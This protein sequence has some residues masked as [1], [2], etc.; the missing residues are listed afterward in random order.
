MNRRRFIRTSAVSSL[1]LLLSRGVSRGF[2]ESVLASTSKRVLVLGGTDFVGPAVVE[3]L[4]ING[5]AVTLFNRGM[6]NPEFNRGMTNPELFSV[7]ERLKGFRS[8]DPKDQDLSALE[9]RH[10]DVAIDIWPNEPEIVA[11]AAEVLK[12][13]T[14]HY[15][16]VSSV[17]AY[18]RKL[19]AKPDVITEDAPMQ[20]WNEQASQYNRNKAE[21]ERR[22]HRIIGEKLTIV[23]PTRIKGHREHDSGPSNL[24]TWLLRMQTGG[25]HIGPGDGHDPFQLVDVKDVARFLAL[26][27]AK[28]LY[29]TFNLTGKLLTFRDYL[30]ECKAA[31]HS[32][33]TLTWI[34]QQFLHEYGLDPD[35][36]L[37]TRAGYFPSWSPEVQDQGVC[38]V[39][40]EKAFRAGWELRPF[41]E[42]AYDCLLDFRSGQ[43]QPST[44]LSPAKEKE[45]LEAWKHRPS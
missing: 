33:T 16:F 18:D 26:A 44:L 35:S 22:L 8:P 30:E 17:G 38:R 39:S 15:L 10:F 1:G 31:T 20:P 43:L 25:E 24:L 4:L 2:I 45:V 34:P 21:S 32:D 19:F 13:R 5:H 9:H 3:A 14:N 36:A 28:A 41:E 23:R 6:T 12:N 11:S 7:V 37:T 40:S 27:I 42:T 29:G